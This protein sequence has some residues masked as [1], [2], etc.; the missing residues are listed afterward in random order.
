MTKLILVA[1]CV[2]FLACNNSAETADSNAKKDSPMKR[3]DSITDPAELS[4]LAGCVDN[5]K[6]RLGEAEAYIYCKC[7][8]QQAKTKF[9]TIDSTTL[10]N[11]EKDTAQV[12]KMAKACE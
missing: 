10:V 11:L 4:F 7:F 2:A 3:T 9:G 8:L 12:A 5:A 6:A 1:T